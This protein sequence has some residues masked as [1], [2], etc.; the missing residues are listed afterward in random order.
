DRTP[1]PTE[2]PA[3]AHPPDPE[4]GR[5]GLRR[6]V[7]QANLSP[8]LRRRRATADTPAPLPDLD[9]ARALSRYQQA[10]RSALA[11]PDQLGPG[12]DS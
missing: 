11:G 3:P 1:D 8:E 5:S 6:R 7:P 10:R 9:A 12:G 4:P 2:L